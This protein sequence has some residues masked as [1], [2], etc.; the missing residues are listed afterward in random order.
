MFSQKIELVSNVFHAPKGV[1]GKA[2]TTFLSFVTR[3]AVETLIFT[4]VIDLLIPPAN[5][6]FNT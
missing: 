1:R 5:N 2:S 3:R 6:N 4:S